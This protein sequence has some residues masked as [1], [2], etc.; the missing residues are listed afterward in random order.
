MNQEHANISRLAKEHANV[1]MQKLDILD[2]LASFES[3]V[4]AAQ[5]FPSLFIVDV[6]SLCT[7]I[8]MLPLV[9]LHCGQVWARCRQVERV[10][11]LIN[12]L[13]CNASLRAGLGKHGRLEQLFCVC[14]PAC[15]RNCAQV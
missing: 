13:F 4:L 12:F 10:Y 11:I 7:C 9:M 5:N 14:A 3:S 2:Q 15:R 6:F 8:L 1:C